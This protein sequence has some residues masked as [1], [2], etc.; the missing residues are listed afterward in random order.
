VGKA[1]DL[2]SLETECLKDRKA[3]GESRERLFNV[4]SRK[5]VG[6]FKID[7]GCYS[8]A[9]DKDWNAGR[10]GLRMASNIK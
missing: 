7:A 4:H 10:I 1:L 5:T 8:D 2:L 3:A 6:R 9:A